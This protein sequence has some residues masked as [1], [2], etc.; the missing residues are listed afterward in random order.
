MKVITVGASATI[1]KGLLKDISGVVVGF[2]S[3]IDAVEIRI[4]KYTVVVMSSYDIE[5]H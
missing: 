1:I 4:D 5:Q 3:E 2:D